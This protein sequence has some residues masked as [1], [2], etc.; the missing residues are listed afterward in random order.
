MNFNFRKSA[1][2]YFAMLSL[3]FVITLIHAMSLICKEIK[4]WLS[5]ED[6]RYFKVS[7][8][9]TFGVEL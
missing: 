6:K 1:L 7:F 4:V 2:K 5:F 3:Y 9:L 8:Q